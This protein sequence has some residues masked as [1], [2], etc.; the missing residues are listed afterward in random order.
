MRNLH[1]G[2]ARSQIRLKSLEIIFSNPRGERGEEKR[3]A[4][5]SEPGREKTQRRGREQEGAEKPPHSQ[6]P[7][8]PAEAAQPEAS[9]GHHDPTT[10]QARAQ[11]NSH[12]GEPKKPVPQPRAKGKG[13]AKL[14]NTK[15]G[16]PPG[17]KRGNPLRGNLDKNETKN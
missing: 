16:P 9:K 1:K 7:A 5:A 10:T 13:G 8:T 15:R 11:Q 14:T 6:R 4:G 12:L 2:G 3:N 17:E